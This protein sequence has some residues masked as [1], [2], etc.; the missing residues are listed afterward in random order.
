[1]KE[2]TKRKIIIATYHT[3]V[4]FNAMAKIAL[5][6]LLAWFTFSMIEVTIYN[7]TTAIDMLA[8]LSDFNLF[9]LLTT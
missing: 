1:M 2:K 8:D 5:V 9:K 6:L 3:H 4:L 7:C